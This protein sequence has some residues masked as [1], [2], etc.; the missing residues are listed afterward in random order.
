MLICLYWPR[1]FRQAVGLIRWLLPASFL[2]HGYLLPPGLPRGLL[3]A[4][5]SWE[6]LYW[7]GWVLLLYRW[8]LL[9]R[10]G[11]EA[12][13]CKAGG[14]CAQWDRCL[15]AYTHSCFHIAAAG[16]CDLKGGTAVVCDGHVCAGRNQQQHTDHAKCSSMADELVSPLP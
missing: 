12:L 8:A 4:G 3:G 1:H 10:R 16:A 15:S 5:G 14:F 7:Q 11:L 13:S 6:P 9:H 2:L